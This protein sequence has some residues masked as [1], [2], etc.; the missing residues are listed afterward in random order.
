M[1]DFPTYHN[2]EDLLKTRCTQLFTNIVK[3]EFRCKKAESIWYKNF[4][5]SLETYQ[6]NLRRKHKQENEKIKFRKIGDFTSR[7]TMRPLEEA[8]R[9]PTMKDL[10]FQ[11]TIRPWKKKYDFQQWRIFT[12]RKTM[13]PLEEEIRLPTMEDLYF[14][15]NDKTLKEVP[16]QHCQATTLRTLKK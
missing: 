15:K 5:E 6:R 11:K 4:E 1:L 16:R 13:R 14:Q 7:K 10:Y 2:I 3:T 12:S 8:I 9:L